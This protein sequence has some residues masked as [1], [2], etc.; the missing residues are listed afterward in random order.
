MTTFGLPV[1]TRGLSAIRR[2]IVF[3]WPVNL[4]VARDPPARRVEKILRK[5]PFSL[6]SVRRWQRHLIVQGREHP[7]VISLYVDVREVQCSAETGIWI[8]D[9]VVRSWFRAGSFHLQF[10]GRQPFLSPITEELPVIR[11]GAVDRCHPTMVRY[12]LTYGSRPT[13]G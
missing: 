2:L 7:L 13:S 4:R 10:P 9:H 3:P 11:S 8:G 6:G 12:S 5:E 1:P